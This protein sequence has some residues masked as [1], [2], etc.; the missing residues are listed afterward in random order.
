MTGDRRWPPRR[1]FEISY[2]HEPTPGAEQAMTR[3]VQLSPTATLKSFASA[4]R[5]SLAAEGQGEAERRRIFD[6]V[7]FD[8]PP[9]L[10]TYFETH[11]RGKGYRP[12]RDDLA[13]DMPGMSP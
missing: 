2:R 12:Q 5:E 3:R 13:D 4:L 8:A 6:S 10:A 11:M 1:E 7:V 9:E